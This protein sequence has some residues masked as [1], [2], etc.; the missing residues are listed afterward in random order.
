MLD[1][2]AVAMG[3]LDVITI[4]VD[5]LLGELAATETR[6]EAE[7]DQEAIE[8]RSKRAEPPTGIFNDAET[9]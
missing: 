3:Q 4:T 1:V 9:S 8:G 6:I 2:V 7:M 5:E